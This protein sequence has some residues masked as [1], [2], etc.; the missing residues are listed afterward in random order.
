MDVAVG[1]AVAVGIAAA[2]HERSDKAATLLSRHHHDTNWDQVL[3]AFYLA[4]RPLYAKH[5]HLGSL[6]YT[7]RLPRWPAAKLIV[8]AT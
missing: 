6:S 3:S 1:V 8:L 5:G 7:L 2:A 4:N